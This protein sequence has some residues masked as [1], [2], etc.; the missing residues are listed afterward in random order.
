MDHPHLPADTAHVPVTTY[1]LQI[2]PNLSF[3]EAID[4]VPYLC[5]LGITDVYLSPILQAA[6]GSTHGYDVVSHSAI[7]AE[8]GGRDGFTRLADAV[9]A[10]GM[11]IVVDVVPNHMAVPTPVWHNRAMWSVLK[12][13][14]DS[15]YA[16]WFDVDMD[17]PILMPILG[18][19]IGQVIANQELRVVH[20]EIPTEPERGKQWLLTY[21]DHVFP[22]AE[23]TQ[24]LPLAVLV[25]R[26][27]YRLAHWKVADEELNYRRFFDVG[28]L[29]AI[30]VEDPEVFRD[31]HALLLELY[32]AGYIDAF[33]VDH[34][35][36]LANPRDYFRHLSQATGKAWIAAEKILEGH[37]SLPSDWP[38]AGTTGYDTAWRLTALQVDPQASLPLGAL[39]QRVSGDSPASY[40]DIVAEAKGQIIDTS[41]AA[42]VRRLGQLIWGIC[43][44]DVRLRDYTYRSVIEC[45]RGLIIE[46]PVYRAYVVPGEPAPAHSRQIILDAASRALTRLDPDHADTMELLTALL[47][48]DEVGSAGLDTSDDR[49]VEAVVRFQQV[50][51][52]VQAKGVEDTAF[53]RWTHLGALTEVGSSPDRF[54]IT[55]DELHAFAASQQENWPATMTC[56]ST[57]DTKRGEDVRS[58]LVLTSQFPQLW[59]ATLTQLQA[60]TAH[61]RP[62]DLE[63]RAEHL[64][65][66]TLVGTWTPAGPISAERFVDYLRKAVREMKTWTTWTAPDTERENA[67][68]V[69][70]T[71]VLDDPEVTRIMTQWQQATASALAVT[72]EATKALQLTLPGVADIYQGTEITQTSLVDP[73]NRRRVD[74]AGCSDLLDRLDA[75]AAPTS[76]DERK[77]QLTAAIARLRRDLPEVFVSARASYQPLPTSSGHV[78]AFTRGLDS[79][80]HVVTVA[81][82]LYGVLPGGWSTQTVVLPPGSWRDVITG[83]TWTGGEEQLVTDLLGERGASILRRDEGADD[84]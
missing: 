14:K 83:R 4:L 54:G 60:V 46:M 76:L 6:P 29:A 35:D 66:Q 10:A 42:E 11:N 80:P 12:R 84:A 49:R 77:L 30:R 69:F 16:N 67:L 70:A 57:H 61:L 37:E 25:E 59:A 63:G 8:A 62:S 48:T 64:L 2:G 15:P 50:C 3:D 19:R 22:I 55:P 13:G 41:L 39:M 7:S 72:V 26:Q 17:Q 56:G 43:Q 79:T 5:R 9:H 75:G 20:R 33:R 47:L 71:A 74:F 53:Y 24:D 36:G 38:V 44:D 73:D 40:P 23:G 34:P 65:W 32:D 51:G 31:T 68:F 52:A 21:Y 18:A 58:R 28:T 82:R 1:R 27:H 45:L 78:C 81:A